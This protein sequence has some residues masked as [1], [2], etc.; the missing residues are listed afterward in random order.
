MR[1]KKLSCCE[2]MANKQTD[3]ILCLALTDFLLS[4]RIGPD[5]IMLCKAHRQRR[6]STVSGQALGLWLSS[7]VAWKQRHHSDRLT[8]QGWFIELLKLP[9]HRKEKWHTSKRM[10]QCVQACSS[11]IQGCTCSVAIHANVSNMLAFFELIDFLDKMLLDM[12]LSCTLA[13]PPTPPRCNT[14][15]TA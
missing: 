13:F 9:L 5:Y 14:R 4:G 3:F 6:Q 12:L 2:G 10:W 11:S 1:R 8:L 15:Q 7:I